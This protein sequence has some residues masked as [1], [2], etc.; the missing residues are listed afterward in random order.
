MLR[1]EKILTKYDPLINRKFSK[2]ADDEVGLKRE[3]PAF[4]LPGDWG[5]FSHQQ[6]GYA[7]RFFKNARISSCLQTYLFHISL[8]RVF[9]I[10]SRK[11]CRYLNSRIKILLFQCCD[12]TLK[13]GIIFQNIL[14]FIIILKK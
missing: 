2:T 14:I 7:V 8:Y 5:R 1:N 12:K 11:Y 9:S 13:Y 6:A 10:I 4:S 3:R